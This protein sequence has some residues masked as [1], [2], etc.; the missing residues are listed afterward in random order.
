MPSRAERR[1]A[2]RVGEHWGVSGGLKVEA[3]SRYHADLPVQRPGVH[4]WTHVAL[5]RTANPT[6]DKVLLDLEN[7]ITIEGPGCY[8][9]EQPY[10]TEVDAMACPGGPH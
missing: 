9:C 7:L 8:W 4:L 10:S 1:R 2:Q 3:R 5:Y 6:A